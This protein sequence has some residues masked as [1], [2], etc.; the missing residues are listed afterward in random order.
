MKA[1]RFF[2]SHFHLIDPRFPLIPNQNYLPPYF[3]KEDYFQR[4][5]GFSLLGGVVVSGSFQGFDQNYLISQLKELGPR[6]VGVTQ[7]PFSCS[8][9]EILNLNKAGIRG[10][11]FNLKRGGSEG[12]KHL[13][14][15]ALRVYELASWHSE[16]YVDSSELN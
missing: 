3:T 14:A 8:N 7:L 2:D 5:T 10:I 16:L 11:R 13:Q 12:I 4:L 1:I 6:F 9:E 15:F